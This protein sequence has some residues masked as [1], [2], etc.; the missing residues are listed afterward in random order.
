MK[1]ELSIFL[2]IA[3]VFVAGCYAQNGAQQ[4]KTTTPTTPGETGSDIETGET[5]QGEVKEFTIREHSFM[6]D[7]STITVNKGDTVRI[8]VINDQGTHDLNIDGYNE[9][10][11]VISAGDSEVIEFVADREGTFDMLCG[12]G[13]HREQGM[14]GTLIVQ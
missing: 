5:G 8:T 9:K 4:D 3:L 13:N 11:S 1:K 12:V 14:E 6:L 7:P 2:T 10:T